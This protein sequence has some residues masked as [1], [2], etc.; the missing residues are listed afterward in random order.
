MK[1]NKSDIEFNVNQSTV[2]LDAIK[3][4]QGAPCE[5]LHSEIR[6]IAVLYRDAIAEARTLEFEVLTNLAIAI[7]RRRRGCS[8]SGAIFDVVVDE[9]AGASAVIGALIA[10]GCLPRI[11]N[12]TK[13]VWVNVVDCLVELFPGAS[14]PTE[15]RRFLDKFASS[16][17]ALRELE[18][19]QKVNEFKVA[20][21]VM[22][23][24]EEA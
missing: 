19:A 23:I 17:E 5:Y 24:E 3:C 1:Q 7:G 4:V 15:L 21:K 20:F 22:K 10:D 14:P 16:Q 12:S 2:I 6:H 8:N 9:R 13:D 18:N 11:P